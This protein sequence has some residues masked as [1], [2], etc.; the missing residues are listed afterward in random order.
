MG[1]SE[2]L[3]SD[4][5]PKTARNGELDGKLRQEFSQSEGLEG[6]RPQELGW[7]MGEGEGCAAKFWLPDGCTPLPLP[8]PST[9]AREP[10]TPAIPSDL[11]EEFLG[12]TDVLYLLSLSCRDQGRVCHKPQLLYSS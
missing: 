6:L 4:Q 8:N 7:G 5:G 12:A 11:P 2:R 9:G 1:G 3:A 10:P